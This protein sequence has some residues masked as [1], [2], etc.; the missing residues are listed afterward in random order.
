MSTPSTATMSSIAASA[1]AD[2]NCTITITASFI[3]GSAS[4]AGRLR[5]SR[6]GRRRRR[7]PPA[8]W[9]VLSSEK[10][11]CSRS[12][13]RASKPADL[14]MRTISTPRASFSVTGLRRIR[15][16]PARA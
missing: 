4:A 9:L 1:A 12:S 11:E 3:A 16:A 2:S 8:I 7:A 6:C 5:Y 13:Y 10:L 15:P 14:A